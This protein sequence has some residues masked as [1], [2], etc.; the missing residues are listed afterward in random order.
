M[1][2]IARMINGEIKL[3]EHEILSKTKDL[4]TF[5]LSK[6]YAANMYTEH[7]DKNIIPHEV[8]SLDKK[9]AGQCLIKYLTS[10]LKELESRKI[11]IINAIDNYNNGNVR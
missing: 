3:T 5:E 10:E 4:I 7:L 6:D 2:Y 9:T 8:R 11:T 1:L